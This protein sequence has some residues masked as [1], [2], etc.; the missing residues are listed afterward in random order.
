[1]L[2]LDDVID[3]L[4]T[5]RGVQGVTAG[6]HMRRRT[7]AARQPSEAPGLRQQTVGALAA[8]VQHR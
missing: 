7:D 5:A 8:T 1:M 3:V 6:R 2:L 4:P